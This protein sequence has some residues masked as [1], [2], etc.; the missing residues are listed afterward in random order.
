MPIKDLQLPSEQYPCLKPFW[1]FKSIWATIAIKFNWPH[2]PPLKINIFAEQGYKSF[3]P[4]W[5]VFGLLIHRISCAMEFAFLP[6]SNFKVC[7]PK[8]VFSI[9]FISCGLPQ[10]AL[11]FKITRTLERRSRFWFRITLTLADIS[12]QDIWYFMLQQP[13][14]SKT[15]KITADKWNAHF[16]FF[17]QFKKILFQHSLLNILR[18]FSDYFFYDFNFQDTY[19]QKGWKTK[20]RCIKISAELSL[21]SAKCL[22]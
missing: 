20:R 21:V 14:A 9:N 7:H 11:D 18:M 10:T 6:H 22:K 3:Q 13:T 8:K 12:I 15:L 4:L 16:K 5:I 2:F 19:K 1:D 17:L